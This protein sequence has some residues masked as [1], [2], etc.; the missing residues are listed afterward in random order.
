MESATQPQTLTIDGMSCAHCIS[1]VRS[2]LET[3]PG[4]TVESVEIGSAVVRL[5]PEAD[6][7]AVH[8]AIEDAGFDLAPEA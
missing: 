1:A 7:I 6:R 8:T 3:V 4:A 2:A 5:T